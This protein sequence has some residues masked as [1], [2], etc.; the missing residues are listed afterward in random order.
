[1]ENSKTQSNITIVISALRDIIEIF[2]GPFLTT[3][4]IKTSSES[5]IDLSIYNIFSYIILAIT[6]LIVGIII[7]KRLK[8]TS[9]RIG[10]ITNFLYIL[11]IIILREKVVQHLGILA[12]LYGFSSSFYYMPF[13]LFITNKIQ[14][15][16]RTEYEV[17]RKIISSVINIVVPICLGAIITVTN[18]ILTAVI[19]LIISLIQII[20]SF[21]LTPIKDSREPF[22]LKETYKII[23]SN[24]DAR[25]MMIV[26][27]LSGLSIT[28][29]ALATLTTILI[30]N[31]F[32]TDFNLGII[33]AISY[34]LQLIAAF[35]YGKYFKNKKD[36]KVII[37]SSI[38]PI[39]TLFILL[40]HRSNV[41]IIMYNIC[42]SVFIN[43]LSMIRMIRLYNVSNIKTTNQVEFWSIRE[44]CLNL[45]RITSFLILL[46]AG[47]TNSNMA[48][49]IAMII[50][51]LIVLVL[52]NI[53]R[54]V[55]Y[56]EIK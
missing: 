17:A 47:I 48:L 29:S 25:R 51:T 45:G 18:Y 28:Y 22:K 21:F 41:T 46:I 15:E 49:N 35:I 5:I 31:A 40:I 10:V 36:G 39:V 55:N 24:P 14:N 56:K 16:N 9:F 30:Y 38:I 12:I 1:M 27:Y 26:E 54:K 6:S 53:L 33:T 44:I 13:N 11:S 43:L 50:L 32:S 37:I 52:A 20:L 42:Y 23:K 34:V 8:L 2:S 19:I 7:K 4:F 3:Y